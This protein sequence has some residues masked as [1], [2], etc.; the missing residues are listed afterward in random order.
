MAKITL[1]PRGKIKLAGDAVGCKAR[2]RSIVFTVEH[3][4]SVGTYEARPN[5][6]GDTI[7]FP[8]SRSSFPLT[9]AISIGS[10]LPPPPPLHR[11]SRVASLRT[12]TT[13]D[14]KATIDRRSRPNDRTRRSGKI[15]S[16]CYNQLVVEM[17]T[18]V[19]FP[20]G[21]AKNMVHSPGQKRERQRAVR[22]GG[23]GA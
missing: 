14:R 5:S 13:E 22:E 19:P 7:F 4:F 10:R 18:V 6:T 1:F 8:R 11:S 23:S 17:Y 16:F 20:P 21:F 2:T 9:T 12:A 3:A 15:Q